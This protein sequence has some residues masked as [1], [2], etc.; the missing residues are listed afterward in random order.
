MTIP[1]FT[2]PV[3]DLFLEDALE[4]TGFQVGHGSRWAAARRPS[5]APQVCLFPLPSLFLTLCT[6]DSCCLVDRHASGM[7]ILT[8]SHQ[9]CIARSFSLHS[10]HAAEVQLQPS[11]SVNTSVLHVMNKQFCMLGSIR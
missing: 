6:P 9:D 10:L 4:L 11:C 7:D 8:C 5:A 1:G 3:R 2:H